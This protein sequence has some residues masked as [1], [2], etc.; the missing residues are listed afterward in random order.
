MPA[1]KDSAFDQ[2]RCCLYRQGPGSD[3]PGV[4]GLYLTRV[5][6]AGRD[7]QA[8]GATPGPSR[9]PPIGAPRGGNSQALEVKFYAVLQLPG[10]KV[11][12]G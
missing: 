4:V 5:R 1:G 12:G 6:P 9:G 3:A 10:G 8:V 7:V 2:R 11:S